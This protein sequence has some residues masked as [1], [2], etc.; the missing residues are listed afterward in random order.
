MHWLTCWVSKYPGGW[1][2]LIPSLVW[3]FVEIPTSTSLYECNIIFDKCPKGSSTLLWNNRENMLKMAWPPVS[4]PYIL[5][6]LL[7]P[8]AL[9]IM[10]ASSM[11]SSQLFIIHFYCC[12]IAIYSGDCLNLREYMLFL[13]HLSRRLNWTFLVTICPLSISVVVIGVVVVVNFSH[14]SSSSPEPLD[15]F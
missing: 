3:K 6:Y 11:C 7:L 9:T 10:F 5:L 12:S 13:G 4:K 8:T 15:Q 2:I 1:F 14:L